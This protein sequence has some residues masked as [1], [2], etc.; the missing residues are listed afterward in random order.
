[1]S[2][3]AAE[4]EHLGGADITKA[5]EEL[6][7]PSFVLGR[8]G[9]IRWVND[10]ARAE[11][12]D[13]TGSHWGTMIPATQ[14]REVEEIL[15]QILCS[16]D[17]AELS[18][19]LLDSDGR[20][21]PREVSAAP[22]KDG[23]TVVGVFG[24]AARAGQEDPQQSATAVDL[25]LTERQ[26]EVLKLLA[27]GKSTGQIADELSVSKTTVRNHIAHILARLEVHTRVQAVLLASRA[28]LVS[29]PP[30]RAGGTSGST[31]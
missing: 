20:A 15:R 19:D 30:T 4:L 24:V 18:I 10:A 31:G 22:L 29:L 3:L 21:V 26:L 16:G 6:P 5:L 7:M 2:R 27:A 23:D 11:R 25:G 1:M 17:P 28:G 9:V 8:D 13:T 12:G 14:S